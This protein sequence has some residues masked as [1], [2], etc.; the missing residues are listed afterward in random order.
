M[1][2]KEEKKNNNNNNNKKENKDKRKNNKKEPHAETEST[3]CCW[4]LTYVLVLSVHSP[5][6]QESKYLHLLL[7]QKN[8]ITNNNFV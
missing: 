6:E 5:K 3:I 1:Q 2:Q 4:Q 7:V 8:N